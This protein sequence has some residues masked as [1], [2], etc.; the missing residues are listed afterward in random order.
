[1]DAVY[2]HTWSIH[3]V[4]NATTKLA[5][6]LIVEESANC[7]LRRRR[8]TNAEADYVRISW[9]DDE[10]SGIDTASEILSKDTSRKRKRQGEGGEE[11]KKTEEQESSLPD[12]DTTL[13]AP[14]KTNQRHLYIEVRLQEEWSAAVVLCFYGG[15]NSS[16]EFCLARGLKSSYECIF[17]WLMEIDSCSYFV[18]MPQIT[19]LTPIVNAWT[20]CAAAAD[21][22][23]ANKKPLVLTFEPPSGVVG[24]DTLSLTIPTQAL[25]QLCK[26]I[27][28]QRPSP[29]QQ[30]NADNTTAGENSNRR[31]TNEQS[32][33]TEESNE[34]A[35][36]EKRD[37]E[38]EE[39]SQESES[40]AS[41]LMIEQ[42]NAL[43]IVRA[44][45]CY[46]R[47]AFRIDI[48]PFRLVK[49]AASSVGS[50][51]CDGRFKPACH[52]VLKN[53]RDIVIQQKRQIS[54]GFAMLVGSDDDK[55]TNNQ[56]DRE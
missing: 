22:N 20:T 4:G 35:T 2:N 17:E 5:D 44:M 25:Q 27:Q 8:K 32:T 19:D 39:S 37:E 46:I 50:L 42:R 40:S 33:S 43:P 3:F 38:V 45:E 55:N 48:R 24:L 23:T 41:S 18:C 14:T 36:T 28:D 34:E 56:N 12:D 10:A 53:I 9:I 21:N 52:D 1:M 51:S 6:E 29:Q 15:D 54:A 11:E 7:Y 26:N 16:F 49:V 31:N 47:E 13:E 30:P